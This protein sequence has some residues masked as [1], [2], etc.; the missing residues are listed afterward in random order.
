M[1]I[2]LNNQAI[3]QIVDNMIQMVDQSKHQVFEITEEGRKEYE[4]LSKELESTKKKV[5]KVY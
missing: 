5:K 1:T 3:D 2:R 4:Y